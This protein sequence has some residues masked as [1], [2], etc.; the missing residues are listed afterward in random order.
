MV[1]GPLSAEYG[2]SRRREGTPHLDA[3]VFSPP[4]GNV[5]SVGID[6]TEVSAVRESLDRFGV[7]YLARIFTPAEQARCAESSDPAPHLAARF[8]AKEATIKALMIDGAI[9]PWTSMEVLGGNPGSCRLH[10]TGSAARIA[11]ERGIDR[12]MVSLSHEADM[13]I[14]IVV[15]TADIAD[16]S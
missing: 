11:Q 8:A 13:A 12:F 9:P 16:Q 6:L 10:L 4:A 14:A 7:R 5:V 1:A 15:A 3:L 2:R